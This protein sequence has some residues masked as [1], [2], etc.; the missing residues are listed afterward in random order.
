MLQTREDW[1]HAGLQALTASGVE[2]VKVETLAKELHISKGSFYHYWPDR[3]TFLEALL[4]DWEERGTRGVIDALEKIASP[5]ERLQRLF[6]I[7]FSSEKRLEAAIHHW[8][9]VDAAVAFRLSRVEE[10]RKAYITKLLCDMGRPFT[11]A[12][13]VARIYYLVYLGW[14][15]W[16]Q[17]NEYPPDELTDLYRSLLTYF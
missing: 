16:S 13:E 2:G 17:R 1:I 10:M 11:Q 7:S 15:D 3:A 4:A 6:E 9:N 12:R 14:V 8:A 5:H